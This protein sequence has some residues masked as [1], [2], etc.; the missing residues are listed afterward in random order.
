MPDHFTPVETAAT[1]NWVGGSKPDLHAFKKRKISCNV[2]ES[3]HNSLAVQLTG[4]TIPTKLSW[5]PHKDK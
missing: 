1:D 5:L 3:K 4:I 2:Q